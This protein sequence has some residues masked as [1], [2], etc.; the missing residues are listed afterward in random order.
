L[1]NRNA[2]FRWD[3]GAISDSAFF[4]SFERELQAL[5]TKSAKPILVALA[6]ILSVILWPSPGWGQE[7]NLE[8]RLITAPAEPKADQVLEKSVDP[9]E[10]VLGA[11][12]ELSIDIW[13]QTGVHHTL[14]VTPEGN[15]LIPGVG[16]IE[17]GGKYLAEAKELIKQAVLGSYRNTQ[18]TVTLLKLKKIKASV[19]GAV[20]TP[21][22]YPV[23]A[24]TRVSE[25]IEEAGGF[26]DR[27]SRRNIKVTHL[28]GSTGVA[29]VF[30][31]ERIGDRSKNPYALAGDVIFVPLRDEGMNTVGVYGA[32]KSEGAFEYAPHDSLMDLVRL[33]YGLT[34]DVDLLRAELVRFNPDDLTTRNLPVDLEALLKRH[35]PEENIPLLPDDRLFIR[36]LPKF[37][38]KD[39]VT[40][41]GEVYYPGVYNIEEDVTTLSEVIA[42]AGGVTPHASLAEAEMVRSYNVVDPEFERLKSIPVADMTESEY[43]YFRLRSREKPGRVACDFE[44][45]LG[46]KLEAYDVTLKDGDLIRVPPKSM[47]VNV[48]GSVINPGL[49]PYEPGKDYRYYVDRAGGFSW[50]ARKNRIL[51]VKAQTGERARP[52]KRRDIDPG[53]TILIPE[54]PERNYW[55]FI[56]DSMLVLANVATVYLVVDQATK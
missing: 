1:R 43:D 11:G 25:M 32:V 23:Y 50:K 5:G 28:D 34:M 31:F 30:R 7:Q 42:K 22:V 33:A 55:K 35:D 20:K 41:Q 24:N 8:G 54:K 12:D 9:A 3:C 29:D 48:S 17:V 2:E 4:E 40:V 36:T 56:K 19:V 10:Y 37:H 26:L 18:V 21:G 44:K 16:A 46:Q 14:T 27:S 45:L 6:I 15:L 47:V 39:Q 49:V 51:I 53:D 38:K 52:S 13:G